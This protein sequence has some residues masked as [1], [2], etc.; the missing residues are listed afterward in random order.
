MSLQP[1]TRLGVYEILSALGAGG[2]GEVY[3]ARDSKLGR[4]VAIKVLPEAVVSDSERV[5][6][7]ERE[8]QLL[9]AI[10]HPHIAGIYGLEQ[11]SSQHFLAMELVEGESLAER[12]QGGALPLAE[13]LSIARQIGE[14]LAAAHDKGI[15][16]RDLKPAN[17][18]L[19]RDGSVKVLDF[20]L[21]KIVDSPS[22]ASSSVSMSPTLS[23]QT[24]MAGTILGSAAYMSPEQA[25]GRIVDKRTDIWA[26]GCVLFEMLSGKRAFEGEDI[27]ETIAAVVRGEPNWDA[28]PKDVPAPVTSVIRRCLV[29]EPRQRF[30]DISIPLYLLAEGDEQP[31]ASA[32][33]PPLAA[34]THSREWLPWSAVA[35]LAVTLAAIVALWA[36]WR[37]LERE[38]MRFAIVPPPAQPVQ[39]STTDRV[40]EISP[41]GRLL[42]YV[43]VVSSGQSRL[44]LRSLD[45]LESRELAAL[46]LRSP[47]FSPD[48]KWIGFVQGNE[49]KRVAV[50]GG[51][52][53]TVM[54][55]PSLPRGISWG[56]GDRIVFATTD[57]STGLMIVPAVG[58]EPQVLTTPGASED[59]IHP[60]V[61][62]GGKAVLFTIQSPQGTQIAVVDIASKKVQPL[63]RDGNQA[64]YTA[65]G[66]IVYVSGGTMYAV[67]FD[68]ASLRVGGDPFP[69]VQG[70]A[71]AGTGAANYSV[72]D[73][74]TLVHIPRGSARSDRALIWVTR[75]GGEELLPLPKRAY[76]ALRISP[77]GRRVALDIRDQETDIWVWDLVGQ[78]LTRLT[79]TPGL[80]S[81]PV[82]TPEG[83]RIAYNRQAEGLFIRPA[84]GT[85]EESL[86][87]KSDL[88]QFAQSFTP[89]GKSLVVTRQQATNDLALI[90]TDGVGKTTP[91]VETSFI[92][93]LAEI[94]PDGRWLA[95]QS[96]ESGQDQ[97]YVRP[98]PNV[99]DGRVLVSRD[100]GSKPVWSPRGGE[101]FYLDGK[102]ALIAVPVTTGAAF[103]M[104]TPKKLFNAGYFSANQAR[105]YDVTRDGQR[106]LFIKDAALLEATNP[107]ATPASI[108]VTLNWLTELEK[109]R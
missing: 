101:L 55:L 45:Q 5:A 23:L 63:L 30:A 100:G 6:R 14:A 40:V 72:S 39:I 106:F 90:T 51:T 69:V 54:R 41:D 35:L 66:H 19:T 44:M 33:A 77:E 15:I 49:L 91:L 22:A 76:F 59:H 28:L 2:M 12:L 11:T 34:P 67:A 82:W 4:D 31:R 29:K 8:A 64:S 38:P 78:T 27:T 85:G 108:V 109:Q 95:Y 70:I 79:F 37:T 53:I 61:L 62:P 10:N 42:A 73:S 21:A 57:R 103:S 48:S 93:G 50:S 47:F 36:P 32:V 46:N 17:V 81:F 97:I 99:N 104:G 16:H 75:D 7:F 9:A 25:R 87:S 3:R 83:K 26:F 74:G 86:L 1:G 58:G 24:T 68:P 13:A 80:E 92:E 60:F 105:S 98:F 94:S 52:P 89:D 56:A 102:S 18:M 65:T 20:G 71:T 107:N 84:D 43:A 88:I 96:D